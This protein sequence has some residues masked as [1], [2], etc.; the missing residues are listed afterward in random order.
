M[1]ANN[2]RFKM[3]KVCLPPIVNGAGSIEVKQEVTTP[4]TDTYQSEMPFQVTGAH[5]TIPVEEIQTLYPPSD[6]SSN[7]GNSIAHITF[8]KKSYPWENSILPK[9]IRV[10]A[11][12]FVEEDQDIQVLP[13]LALICISEEE[14]ITAKNITLE[15]LFKN[16]DEALFY[17]LKQMPLCTEKPD[18]ICCVIDLP[19]DLYSQIMPR[20]DEIQYLT[21]VKLLDLHDKVDDMVSMDGYFSVVVSNRF[22]PSGENDMKKST[23]HLVSLEGYE[24]YLPEGAKYAELEEKKTVR[25]VSLFSWHVFST[26]KGESDFRNIITNIDSKPLAMT[27][28]EV[29][30]RGQI[31]LHHRTRTGEKTVSLYRGPLIPYPPEASP[32]ITK[33]TADGFMI[34]DP[35]HGLMDASYSA[36]WQLG[37]LLILKNQAIASALITWKKN[38]SRQKHLE[39]NKSVFKAQMQFGLKMEQG[40]I[41]DFW[42]N[43]LSKELLENELIAPISIDTKLEKKGDQDEKLEK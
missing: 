36:A 26:Q 15:D 20:E 14:Q 23:I 29:L 25:L 39:A 21:H 42:V 38:I 19:L 11:D 17:P 33:H 4:Q 3:M 18:S 41:I 35:E 34:Y 10:G 1:T 22:I 13:W 40:D 24:G 16:S 32:R 7:Y 27:E 30:R 8:K 5:F 2:E 6:G 12:G 28:N 9:A 43:T 37:R 31:P